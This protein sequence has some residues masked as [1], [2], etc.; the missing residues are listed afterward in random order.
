M[1]SSNRLHK[2]SAADLASALNG[3]SGFIALIFFV[4]DMLL[5][6]SVFVLIALFLDG[7]DG[8][9]ARKYGARHGKGPQIDSIADTV[10]FCIAPATALYSAFYLKDAPYSLLSLSTIF[11]SSAIVFTGIIRLG[12]FCDEGFA[13][14]HFNGLPTPASALVIIFSVLTFSEEGVLYAPWVGILITLVMASLMVLRI[15]YP[16]IHGRT[17]I[18]SGVLLLY[19]LFSLLFHSLGWNSPL[20]YYSPIVGL[21]ISL[22]YVFA[23]PLYCHIFRDKSSSP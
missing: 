2:V 22:F 6:G 8:I 5:T 17:S 16:K 13:L 10:S 15:C 1:R 19:L 12:T 21:F 18:L 14:E 11:A 7:L 4:N 9:L 20:L 3:I 23:G